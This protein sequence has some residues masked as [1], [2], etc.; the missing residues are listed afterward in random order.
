MKTALKGFLS[1]T[2]AGLV[3]ILAS[4]YLRPVKHSQPAL[5]V[6]VTV[7]VTVPVNPP[8]PEPDD[9]RKRRPLFPWRPGD[10]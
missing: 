3:V 2:A 10:M 8:A 6:P 9:A 5:S 4:P 1:A 7:P